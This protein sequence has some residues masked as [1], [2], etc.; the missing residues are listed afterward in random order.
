MTLI[1][2]MVVIVIL[3]TLVA[4]VL[5]LVSPNND[6]RKIADAARSLQTF[7]LQAQAEAARLGRPV[8]VGFRETGVDSGVALE[9][10]QMVVP[11]PYPGSSTL[12]RI[13]VTTVSQ[14]DTA[15]A[16]LYGR[17]QDYDSNLVGIWN[18]GTLFPD[19]GGA[20]L[21][22]VQT[23]MAIKAADGSMI[24][25]PLP[26]RMFRVG[27]I[28]EARG[29]RFVI[30]DDARHQLFRATAEDSAFL[31]PSENEGIYQNALICVRL[32]DVL[33]GNNAPPLAAPATGYT[34]A[35]HRQPVG[36][37]RTSASP[38]EQ[39]MVSGQPPLQLPAGVAVDLVAS[40]F[41]G[42]NGRLFDEWTGLFGELSGQ[43]NWL[44][45]AGLMF[46]P[47]GAI[48]SVWVNGQ[49]HTDASRVFLLLGR[50]ENGNPAATDY[51][52][53]TSAMTDDEFRERQ[54]RVNWL[55]LDS[56]WVMVNAI[57]GRTT[58]VPNALV[59]PRRRNDLTQSSD[60]LEARVAQ[61]EAAHGLA[62]GHQGEE[63]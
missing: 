31:V 49:R 10:Y 25:D 48:D 46:S 28:I 56:R 30:V 16:N 33:M 41:E 53:I 1:E 15:G 50:V 51:T 60:A 34:Y 2:L 13:S 22:V 24:A 32:E 55:N 45:I 38:K 27:D 58:V 47:S 14:F 42:P 63:H 9:A 40:G 59:D 7:L 54:A 44:C 29:N 17:G 20:K 39:I 12:S 5:P 19:Y 62:H 11:P 3:I 23:H 57:D 26:P 18:D 52:G 21:Y 36:A 43:A 37:E 35:I 8:G 6:S 4:G 61:I